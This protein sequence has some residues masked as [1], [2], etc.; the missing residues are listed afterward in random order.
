MDFQGHRELLQWYVELGVDETI[1]D[2]PVNRF[3]EP[4]SA[5]QPPEPQEQ[6]SRASEHTA[7][8]PARPDSN[9]ESRGQAPQE[10]GRASAKADLQSDQVA[11][12]VEAATSAAAAADDLDSLRLAM[13]AFEHCDLKQGAKQLVFSD[14]NPSARLMIVGEGPGQE[15]DIQGK[16]FVGRAGRLLDLM[17]AAIGMSRTAEAA[18]ES[19]YIANAVPWRPP[20]NRAPEKEEL[21][22]MRPFLVRHIELAEPDALVLM[23][24]V[25]CSALLGRTGITR[26][27]GNW[28]QHQDI[29]VMP[30]FHPAY[31]LRNPA[32]KREAWVDLLRI[33]K[34]MAENR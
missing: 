26:M 24:N 19:L 25:P 27:R 1:G 5:A 32:A 12:A 28:L 9:R 23:G 3:R 16:P 6:A 4:E 34:R 18:D 22:I 14:G 10:S 21:T 15:E 7:A 31:L 2:V 33:R 20:R 11:E 17:F 29:P 8:P 30:T 13:D